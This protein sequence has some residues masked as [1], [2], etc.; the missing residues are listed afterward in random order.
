VDPMTVVDEF[1]N[2]LTTPI[3]A[4]GVNIKVILHNDL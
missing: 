4:T 1:N 2:I 3:I